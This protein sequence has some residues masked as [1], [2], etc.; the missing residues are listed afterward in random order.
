MPGQ[1][2]T[3][4]IL[5]VD[6]EQSILKMLN[7]MLKLLK[8]E[9]FS[10][11][12]AK[13]AIEIFKKHKDEIQLILLDILMPEMN[14]MDAFEEFKKIKPD[15]EIIIISGYTNEPEIINFIKKNKLHFFRK[16]FHIENLMDEIEKII[17]PK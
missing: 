17:S 8:V 3:K 5:L 10:T 11:S 1:T 9:S 15:I 2:S 12:N 13:E 7:E 16:P 14:G 6:D 4:K